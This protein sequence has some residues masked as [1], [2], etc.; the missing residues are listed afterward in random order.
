MNESTLLKFLI[1]VQDIP[2]DAIL[3]VNPDNYDDYFVGDNNTNP[4]PKYVRT[5]WQWNRSCDL[6]KNLRS[7]IFSFLK[8]RSDNKGNFEYLGKKYNYDGVFNLYESGQLPDEL[9][10]W[11][12]NEVRAIL[13]ILSEIHAEVFVE[14]SLPRYFE[15]LPKKQRLARIEAMK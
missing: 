12:E 9:K 8:G 5:Y 1:S 10:T 13:K 15:K 11:L 2:R 7:E 4:H 6:R 3:F 14:V